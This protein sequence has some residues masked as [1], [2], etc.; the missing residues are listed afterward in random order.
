MSANASG[1]ICVPNPRDFGIK[2][3]SLREKTASDMKILPTTSIRQVDAFTIENEPIASIDL[4][5]RAAGALAKAVEE[6]W[7]DTDTPFV[8]FAGPGNNGGDALAVARLLAERGY[9]LEVYLF[10]TKGQLSADC[11]TNMA[12]LE[13]LPGIVF[14]EITSRFVPPALTE[15]HVVID[16]LFGSGLDKPLSGGFA[17][18][19]KYINASPAKVVSVDIPSGLMG[20]DNSYNVSSCIVR[21]DVT[22]TLQLPKLAFLFAENAP[23]VGEWERLD[24]GLSGEAIAGAA[25]DY[26]LTEPDDLGLRLKKRDKFAHKGNF[27]R[28]LLIAGSQGMAG[29]SVLSA[30][31]CLRSGVG[32]LTVHV[33]FCNNFIV[34]TSVPEA[35][36][37]TDF[38]ETCF[39]VATDTDDYQA[40]GIGPGLGRLPETENALMEQI[41]SCQVPM[42]VDADALNLLGEHRACLDRLPKGSILTPHPKELERLVGKCRNSY[43]RL[44]KARELARTADVHIVLKGAYSAVISPSGQCWFN[45]TGNPGMATGGSGDVLTGV[46]LALLAQGYDAETSARLGVCVHGLAGDIAARKQ[47]EVGM[48]AGD[49]VASLPMAWRMMEG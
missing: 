35:M 45:T 24:I 2:P 38:S 12:R 6:R 22:L 36:V 37:E 10:N 25:T 42:V 28:A 8:V 5:E 29:A 31:A 30:C 9:G 17:S 4:M 33:P 16:G 49:I 27:G 18:V 20:E 15:S 23:Y 41:E 46:L 7:N 32:L 34:Q 1:G 11:A 39:S 3:L 43:E 26:Y 14:R 19:V 47:G 44:M 40:V 48:T 13:G 21:A